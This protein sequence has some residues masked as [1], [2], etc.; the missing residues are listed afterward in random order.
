MEWN[1]SSIHLDVCVFWRCLKSP[2][3]LIR[4]LGYY[5]GKYN[6]WSNDTRRMST[7]VET[8]S[9]NYEDFSDSFLT[10]TTCLNRYDPS[11]HAPKL[12]PCSHTI[13]HTC[14]GRIAE[15]ATA[16]TPP[17]FRCPICRNSIVVPRGGISALPPSFLVNQLLDLMASQHRE[18][19]PKCT[20]HQSE[21]LLLCESCDAVFCTRCNLPKQVESKAGDFVCHHEATVVPFS[22]ALKRMSKIMLYK[23]QQC[24]QKLETG[25]QAILRECQSLDASFNTTKAAINKSVEAIYSLVEKHRTFLVNSLENLRDQKKGVLHEQLNILKE[26]K[27]KIE[28]ICNLDSGTTDVQWEMQAIGGKIANLNSMLGGMPLLCDPRENAYM[29]F[30]YGHNN[31]LTDLR[32]CLEGFGEIRHSHTLP[33]LCKATLPVIASA[34]LSTRMTIQCHDLNGEPCKVGGDPIT[35][36]IASAGGGVVHHQLVD[37]ENGSYDVTFTPPTANTY[38][39]EVKIFDRHIQGSPFECRVSE[40]I[41]PVN[42]YSGGDVGLSRPVNI[43]KG[44]DGKYYVLDTGNDRIAVMTEDFEHKDNILLPD[45]ARQG[46][47]GMALSPSST[48]ICTNWRTREILELDFTGKIVHRFTHDLFNCPCSIAVNGKGEIFVADSGAGLIF[49]FTSTGKYIRK[50]T[51]SSGHRLDILQ[52]ISCFESEDIVLADNVIK[53]YEGSGRLK[54]QVGGGAGSKTAPA[55]DD[56][57]QSV[58]LD[59]PNDLLLASK[60]EKRRNVLEVWRYSTATLQF[61]IDSAEWKLRRPAG[62]V[63]DGDGVHVLVCDVGVGSNPG[64]VLKFRYA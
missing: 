63:L 62:M 29:F 55:K 1:K 59:A 4:S 30:R 31:I 61:V 25:E 50:I 14:L 36:M 26:E 40:H 8:V 60:T 52:A 21:E 51:G 53:I 46:V 27:G 2:G 19:V 10:C 18:V 13:C 11:E 22:I 64:A 39:V 37:R 57:Y 58:V 20:S 12:L 16:R 48:L 38:S 15:T 32:V 41:N 24:M 3:H 42:V 9:I 35:V 44:R 28:E 56:I 45:S 6:C 43:V 47:T 49:S 54:R 5:S 7:L 33:S 17:T 23:A 34:H